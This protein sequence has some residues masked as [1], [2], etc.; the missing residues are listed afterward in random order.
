MTSEDQSAVLRRIEEQQAALL[1]QELYTMQE[2]AERWTQLEYTLD[3]QISILIR[4]VADMQAAGKA[5][6]INQILQLDRYQTLLV[7]AQ[8]EFDK[9]ILYA[10]QTII[11]QQE[12]L[13]KL[14]IEHA[15]EII[16]LSLS[17]TG[18]GV[19][20]FFNIL[21][22][23]AVENMIALTDIG[24][25]VYELLQEA[26]PLAVGQMTDALIEGVA[27][28]LSPGVTAQM[29]RDGMAVGLSHINT[30][31]RTEQ[32]RVYRESSRKQYEE[33][34]AVPTY[35]RMCARQDRTCAVCLALDGEIYKSK[36][37]MN[38][39]P[40]DRCWMIPHVNGTDRIDRELGSD[41]FARQDEATQRKIL[42]AGKYD[43]YKSGQIG[44]NDLVKKYDHP[45]WGPSLGEVPLSDLQP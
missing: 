38:V 17:E 3:A 35:E 2:M 45:I 22:I 4:E 11:E 25:P 40:N 39:H 1:S 41:W 16:N 34:K 8:T 15:I 32:L 26:Y 30:I 24:G 7:Q 19:G 6:G 33:S 12:L 37:L 44:L 27:L 42:G 14:G 18:F 36:Q 29:M 31:A 20:E 23:S 28:G 13:A 5:V 21:P 43:L 9:Y 10:S